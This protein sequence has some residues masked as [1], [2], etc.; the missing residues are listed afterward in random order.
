MQEF[1]REYLAYLKLERNLSE[2]TIVSYERDLK[3]VL[4]FFSSQNINDLNDVSSQILTAYFGQE[5]VL[6][7]TPATVYRCICSIRGFFKYLF[8]NKYINDNPADKL[9]SVKISRNLPQVLS[10]NEIEKILSIP[11]GDNKLGLRDKALLEL[12]YSSGLRVSEAINLK[13]TDLFFKEEVIRVLGKG[14]KERMVPIGSSALRWMTEYLKKSRPLLQRKSKS[15]SIVF[16]NNRGNKISRMGIWKIV[17]KYV[18]EAGIKKEVHPH[19][20]RHSFATH[21]IEG[22]ADLRAVQEMLGHSDISTT[23][24][25]T[26]IDREYVK[27][28][29]RDYHPRG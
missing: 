3:K 6:S 20:L 16:L 27:Q 9:S 4:D 24:I 28:I 12:L 18:D 17:K 15:F 25:Y 23:Q 11:K 5:N 21:L 8:L 2:N 7:L 26:H 22:G 10:F 14:S 1:L 13:T 19:T 29:H